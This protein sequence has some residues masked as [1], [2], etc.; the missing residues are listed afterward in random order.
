MAIKY[1]FMF[2]GLALLFSLYYL[3]TPW[4]LFPPFILLSIFF[5]GSLAL[6]KGSYELRR[7]ET[8]PRPPKPI[9]HPFLYHLKVYPPNTLHPTLVSA[10]IDDRIHRVIDLVLLHHV[11]PFYSI[12]APNEKKFFDSLIPEVWKVLQVLLKRISQVDTLKL[13]SHDSIEVLRQHFL[14]FHGFSGSGGGARPGSAGTR[15]FP[16]LR[17]YPYLE[18]EEKELE[19]LRKA[20]DVLLCVCLD[21]EYLECT[22]I[23][24]I[25]REFLVCNIVHPMI[26]RVCEPD[27]INQ[28]LLRYLVQR[29]ELTKVSQKR[30][31]HSETYE[32]FMQHIK[33]CDDINELTHIR[34]SIITD[35]MQVRERESNLHCNDS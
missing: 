25:I 20:I 34:S 8:Q 9:P 17:S 35:I 24:I 22:P 2:L 11:R 7:A 15:S 3:Y 12:V 33:K 18:N 13:I 27:Y 5:G 10:N 1:H 16:N 4:L 26:E 30:Y 23:R 21:R 29:E 31:A 32:D 6:F 28:K 19:F 14:S